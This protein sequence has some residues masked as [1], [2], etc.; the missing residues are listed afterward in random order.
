MVGE[1][2]LGIRTVASFNAEIKFYEDYCQTMDA[3]L[4]KGK[5]RAAYG[6][7]IAGLAFGS[8]FG[9]YI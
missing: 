4:A 6:G 3:M 2:V 1:V 7:S 9:E 5:K 8:I